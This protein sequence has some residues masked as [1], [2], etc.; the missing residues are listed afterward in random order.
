MERRPLLT[1]REVSAYLRVSTSTLTRWHRAGR[2]PTV[3]VGQHL[4]VEPETL[5]RL[6]ERLKSG[7]RP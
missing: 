3:R 1:L 4:R 5:E 7:P 2:F 6:V